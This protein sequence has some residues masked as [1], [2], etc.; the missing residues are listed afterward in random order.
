M[1]CRSSESAFVSSPVPPRPLGGFVESLSR[2]EVQS[3][4]FCSWT[5]YLQ[6]LLWVSI[7]RKGAIEH[8]SH[9]A[10]PSFGYF[11]GLLS[12]AGVRLCVLRLLG[13]AFA[14]PQEPADPAVTFAPHSLS[15]LPP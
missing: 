10:G 12:R 4:C 14:K 2:H 6:S 11:D 5:G 3:A 13:L 8:Y 7:K 15:P 9:V 1:R